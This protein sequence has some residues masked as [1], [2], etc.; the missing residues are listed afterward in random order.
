MCIFECTPSGNILQVAKETVQ[1]GVA[2][3][4]PTS[5]AGTPLALNG[6]GR[7]STAVY[8]KNLEMKLE[9]MEAA[10]KG[11][12][13]ELRTMKNGLQKGQG[14]SS[15]EHQNLQVRQTACDGS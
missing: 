6:K 12:E 13:L 3:S 15:G 1:E 10:K 11:L 9:D 8:A 14:C 4:P 2:S 7:V 5:D